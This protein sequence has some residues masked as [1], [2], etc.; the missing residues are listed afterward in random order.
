MKITAYNLKKMT[1]RELVEAQ[2]KIIDEVSNGQRSH[3]SPLIGKIIDALVKKG[4]YTQE[5]VD[6]VKYELQT[7]G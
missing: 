1:T 6:E 2:D 5:L 4:Y 3:K 7:F